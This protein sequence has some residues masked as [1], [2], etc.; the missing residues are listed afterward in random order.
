MF[1]LSK[2]LRVGEGRA[3]KRLHKIADQ[4]IA[5]ED[6]F[7]NLT[8]EEL[9]A[10]TAEFK[11]RIAGGE[12]LDEIFLEAF[13][14]AREAAWRVLG[15]K[16]YHVQIM[17]GAALHF[18]NVA[19]M[20]TG[21][22]KTLTCVLPA[23]LN[24]LEGKGV[25]VVTVN[26]YLAK[27]DAEMMGRVHRYLGLEVG[28]ILSDM[29]PDERREAYAADITYGTN[30]E[31]G[32]DYLRDN[33]ARSLSD[34]VQRGHN[35]AIVDEVDS[36]LIDEARTPLIISGP[37]DGTS[38]FYNVFAQIV[39]RMTKD[40][41]YEV[42]ERKKTVGVKEEGVEYV[43]DQLGIDNLYAPEHSQLV[44]YLNN[45]IKAQEL[46]TR[47]KD[48]IVRNGEVMIVDGFTGRVLAGRRYNEG[49]HQAIEA[50]ERVEIKNE[51]QTL[52]TVTLQNYFRL[53]TKL[54]GMTGTAE[55]EAAE[56]NQIYKLDVI[57]IPTNRPNQRED[58][59]DLVYK[60]QEAKFAAV[61]D[62]IAERTEKGQ[63]V[64][65]GTVSVERSEY[66]SQ[67]LT[68][69][70]IKHN[71]LN[72]KHHEQE[73][74][75]VA[76]AGLPGAVTVATNMAGRG[77]DIVLGGN[78]EILLDIK[79]RERGLDP[80]EDEE[81][82]Q[83]AW[84]AELP[85]MKQRCE[86]RGDKVR[87]AGGL[88]VLGTER[89]ESRRIDN[90]L[91]GRSARQGDPGSTR[92]YLSMRDDLM[93][94]FVGPTMENMMNRLNVPD[95]VPI[96]SKTVTNS[97]KGAQ[98]QVENQ[99]FEMR[100]NV[101]KYDEVMNEQRKVIYSERREIL[102]SADISRYIQNMIEETVSAYV[103]GATANGYVEDWDL[104]KL[105]NALE[106]LYDP[107]INW[108]DLVEG[109]E[110]GKPGEL[111]AEDLRTALVN[112]AH[113]EYAKLEE[114]VS[115]IGG[116]AQIR[117]IERMVLM[118]VIDTKWREHL[119][120]MDYLKE[121][122]GLRAMAQRDPLVEYQKEGGDMFN[123]MKDG[124]KEETVRQL[125]LLRKQFIKQDAEVAD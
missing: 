27:R 78:P 13:A 85:A 10:K 7:A 49:M 59:T 19:E 115:A 64:L 75:I 50:K 6:K 32:F 119:Y 79:L 118:P 65:V 31:L 105:W 43:E 69:R 57:A 47:D 4:V 104:D 3:V 44:S 94:R 35:Y 80:F 24:A 54:A 102:E 20:R 112:D 2:V 42:D 95:D 68:K 29:R 97:I 108:T 12:G 76:Q 8:D 71:V 90:Q 53:Y 5:L 67:L 66:L 98:A 38:Q 60:T 30:N 111:S 84:D 34:L 88:Y 21:E 55:T 116:E 25:H 83:E 113:A 86:E 28:V 61:V 36:I 82:Y 40:V 101:L 99:N 63:P 89:H 72:A 17:G 11:E 74:Q 15:Q 18:G 107:S 114:A 125:F 103:D 109:S 39:P 45:A 110:Y 87:E 16:H 14:T 46:F 22:G 92:F 106:A 58:L 100:K 26:D 1:G 48:Y 117:N 124:I 70:G 51:N 91:R 93:V 120:E 123:G 9:K 56:L 122:I 33:M 96:E 52:A 41:H 73:A 81:S 23:Y 37:V 62:D 121:G 77:T